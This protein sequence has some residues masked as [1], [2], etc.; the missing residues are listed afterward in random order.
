MGLLHTLLHRVPVR[1][2]TRVRH[3]EPLREQ[4]IAQ[5]GDIR[6]FDRSR[7]FVVPVGVHDQVTVPMFGEVERVECAGA[8]RALDDARPVDGSSGSDRG[9]PAGGLSVV[10]SLRRHRHLTT[11]AGGQK[12]NAGD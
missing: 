4:R 11:A 8:D 3:G 9:R 6:Q 10:R 7:S 5:I 2:E 1:G 12:Q